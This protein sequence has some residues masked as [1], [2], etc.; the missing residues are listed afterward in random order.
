[1]FES[2]ITS[3]RT[4][5]EKRIADFLGKELN[6]FD[7]NF[8]MIP[9]SFVVRFGS[10]VQRNM[11]DL[12]MGFLNKYAYMYVSGEVV[13]GDNMFQQCAMSYHMLQAVS[14][15]PVPEIVSET[16]S[17]PLDHEPVQL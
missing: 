1:M 7:I 17:H 6:S 4:S 13:P 10:G 15:A 12:I 11:M 5:A 2:T 14:M 8:P 9:F 3:S 16:S